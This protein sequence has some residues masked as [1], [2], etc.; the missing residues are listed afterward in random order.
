MPELKD[1]R[2]TLVMQENGQTGCI[3]VGYEW[4]IKYKNTEGVNF[5]TFQRDFDLGG[6]RNSFENVARE[7]MNC[8]PHI[9]IHLRDFADGNEKVNFIQSLLE[10]GHPCLIS[11]YFVIRQT[12]HIMPV[13]YINEQ[14]LEAIDYVEQIDPPIIKIFVERRDEVIRSHSRYPGGKDIA[15]L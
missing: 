5:D 14:R 12:Y 6:D 3:P 4:M 11:Y 2:N 9:T 8:Y 13:V 15:W 1:W 10:A 7:V